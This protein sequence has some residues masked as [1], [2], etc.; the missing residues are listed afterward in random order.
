[1]KQMPDSRERE[2]E[3]ERE[4]EREREKKI[5]NKYHKSK[6]WQ[7]RLNFREYH[8]KMVLFVALYGTVSICS[9]YYI[10]RKL[11]YLLYVL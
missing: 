6:T 10:P 11:E 4:I 9:T 8:Q 5:I 3:R 1:M 2:R 7:I